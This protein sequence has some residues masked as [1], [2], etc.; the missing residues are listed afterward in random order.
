M[1]A[2]IWS[3]SIEPSPTEQRI[4]ARCKKSKLF[5][6][7]RL[8]RHRLFDEAFQRELA[9]MYSERPGGKAVVAPALLAMVVILQAALGVSDEEAVEFAEMDRRWQ[10]LLGTLGSE[11][12]PFSQGGLFNFR[13][14]L[15]AHD[16]DRRLLER[17]IDL[18]RETRGFGYTALRAAFDASPLLGAGRVEDTFNLIGHA[19]RDVVST[20]AKKL[21]LTM[22]EAARRAGIPLLTGTSLKAALDINWDDPA[23]KKAALERLLGQVRALG[24]FL[25]RELADAL[26]GPPLAEQWATVRQILAQ[27]LEPDPGGGTRI[28]RGVAKERRVS[29]RD[30]HMRHG[31]KSKSSRF[32]G[33][34]RHLALDVDH[35]V[36]L[37]AAITPGNRPEGEAA[38]DLFADVERQGLRV[39]HLHIDRGYLAAPAVEARRAAGTEVYCK[40]FPLHNAGRFTKADFQLDL[41][42]GRVTCPAGQSSP[43][44]PGSVARFP[45]RACLPCPLRS[46]CTAAARGRSLSIHP[47]EPFLIELRARQRT[48]EGRALLRKRIP[49]EHSLA[50]IA[51]TQGRRARYVGVRKNLF[52]LRRHAAVFNLYATARS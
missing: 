3:P 21:N 45:A 44:V 4:L 6:F 51:R 31:R 9:A 47:K 18:A 1:P 32:D 19:A 27:D 11:D 13:Q 42:A 38:D 15:I 37:G 43:L 22:E 25:Q 12:A 46:R 49:V 2:T 17:T 24:E 33:F 52:D 10:M 50:G 14:R 39:A 30:P 34:K 40:P 36:I 29:V 28:R 48:L 8:N 26:A 41:A 16:L 20:V 5:I 23:E 35:G 7:L